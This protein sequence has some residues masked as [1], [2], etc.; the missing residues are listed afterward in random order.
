MEGL[1]ISTLGP[2]SFLRPQFHDV[3]LMELTKNSSKEFHTGTV[4]QEEPQDNL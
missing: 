1:F 3:I 4:Q 2:K